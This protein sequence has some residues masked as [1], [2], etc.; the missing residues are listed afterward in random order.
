MEFKEKETN[1]DKANEEAALHFEDY[2]SNKNKL[3]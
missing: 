2:T 1:K 3:Y